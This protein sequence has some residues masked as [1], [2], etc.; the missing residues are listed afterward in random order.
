MRHYSH[1]TDVSLAERRTRRE[2]RAPARYGANFIEGDRL[3]DGMDTAEVESDP[4]P[5]GM[6]TAEIVRIMALTTIEFEELKDEPTLKEA[7]KSKD[8]PQWEAAMHLELASLKA[9]EVYEEVDELPAGKKAVGSKWVLLIKR[10]E[11]GDVTRYK[12]RL[13]AQG[14]TQIPGQD[15]NHTF[16]PVA[17]WDSIRHLLCLATINNWELRHIDIKS[18]YLN[19][20]LEEE[21]YLR[22]P[23]ITGAG[24]WRLLKALYGLKQSGRQWYQ[25]IN[26]TYQS[27]GMTRCGSDWSVHHRREGENISITATSVDDILLASNSKTEADHF[28][29]QIRS[30]YSITDNG[31]VTWLLGCRITRWRSRRMLKIDQEQYV[32]TILKDFGMEGCNS[33]AVPMLARLNIDGCPQTAEERA[34]AATYRYRELV[35]K[36]MYLANC[37]RPDITSANL[38]GS[39]LILAACTGMPPNTFFDT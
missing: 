4:L 5:D 1:I 20:D 18:A 27:L 28:T 39:C 13:V 3:P 21:I 11:H 36:V 15:F 16:A 26:S 35:G 14:F 23:E 17:R 37:T 30:K 29:D 24:F 34:Q 12:A 6:D 19:G 22:R 2:I 8:W 31:D 7:M 38:L 25:N 32:N 10:D 33:V 9:M